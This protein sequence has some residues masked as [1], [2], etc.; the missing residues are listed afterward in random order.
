[1][2]SI[3]E[4]Q[5]V[6]I[7]SQES[8]LQ[9]SDKLV[10][11]TVELMRTAKTEEDLRIGFEKALDPLLK[12][13][14]V[15]SK[16]KYERLG[17]ETK[18][19]YRGR[20]DAVHGQVI[21]EYEPPDA[22][23]SERAVLHA[24]EQL[25]GYMTAEA[26]GHKAEPFGL[27]SRLVGVGFDGRSIFFVQYSRKKN[28]KTTTIDKE[29][30]T[31]RGPYPFN[32]ESAR[33]F[34]TYLRAL[35]RLPLT[36]EHL[37]DKFGPKSKIAP[38]AIS[39]FAD[40]L[41]N[42]RSERVLV[43][44]NEWKRLFGIVYG[45]QF[46]HQQS[47]E[48]QTLSRLYGVGK[49]TDFQELL[50][51]VHTYL[52]LLMKLIAVEL[53][54][55]KE[56]TFTTSFSYQLTHTSKDELMAQLTDIEDGGVYAKR[57]ITNFLEGD[58]FRWYLDASSPRFEEAIREIARGLSEFEP[59]TTTIDPE[60]TRD[61]LKKLYQYLVPQEV[62]H[63]LGEY[64]TPDWLAEL[65][66]NEVGY[67]GDTLKRLLDPACGS[68]TFMVL[69][70]QR[71]KD[72]GRIH[73]EP[74]LETAKRIVANIW[75]FDLNPLAVIAART[76]YLFALGHLV[77]ELPQLE[78]PIYLADSV[79]W[80]EKSRQMLLRPQ[81]ESVEIHTSLQPFFIPRIW[82]RDKGFLLRIAA[83]LIE[84]MAKSQ[85]TLSEAM[86]RFK[87]EGLVFPP[88]EQIVE[89]FYKEIIKLEKDGKNGIWARFLKNVSA[90]MVA[91]KFDFVIGNPPWIRWGYLS[92]EYRNATLPMWKEYGLF[93][94][95]GH[96]ARLGGGEKDFSMLFTY[97]AADY[98]LK[99]NARL[100]FLITQEI[101]KSK[102]AGEGF[103][104]FQLGDSDLLQVIKAH[105]LVSV[106]P[107]EGA[108]N[109]TAAIILKKGQKTEYP[110]PYTVWTR[111]KGIG[112]Q[113]FSFPKRKSLI[114]KKKRGKQCKIATDLTLEEALPLLQK[115]RLLAQPIGSPTGSWQT[116]AESQKGLALI[117]GGNVY[118]ARR[119]ASTEPYGVFW[120]EVKQVLTN[121]DL[122][123]RNL[124]GK[125]KREVQQVEERIEADLVF[126]AVRGSDI[127]RWSATPRIFVLMSQDA[128]KREPYPESQM[129]REWPRT[130]GYLTRFKDILLSRGSKTV[131]Q[132]AERTA[133]YAMFGI[134]LY[135]IAHYK[136]IW[137]RMASDI[138]AAV[139]SQHKTPF[140]YKTVI[141]TDTTSLFATDNEDEAHYLC[142]VINSTP[143]RE[144]IKSYSSAGRGFGAP[145]VMNHVG[146]PKFDSQNELHQKLAQLS[147]TL[148]DLKAKNKLD[149]V[150]RL[151]EEVDDFVSKLFEKC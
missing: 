101:F 8:L 97:A 86:E 143:V 83:P 6:N 96:A 106:Q 147:K 84:E 55:L 135:T 10:G 4:R 126:P 58:F 108:A 13:I 81:G 91:E 138:V 52:A 102:G 139:I 49:E 127:D 92:Q 22:F 38:M 56:S 44:F 100:G 14:G 54:T 21:I 17:V 26:Q 62:R 61:L 148:H 87:K 68:G 79:L 7:G 63:K 115:K 132:L 118:Q 122:I 94:L 60:S 18:T 65:V 107:F 95:R 76:N 53:I 69:A 23:S 98:Y 30:F 136:V 151:E 36:S 32:P 93:S 28:G 5:K 145:S 78:I 142:A 12:S 85:Y 51:S 105:D 124:P 74:P 11:F 120:L 109:K 39:A 70:I 29:L 82:V 45:E 64:Y 31:R 112:N 66:L 71:A 46:S 128:K 111:K 1:M 43:F 137:K 50:F 80:P 72:Y 99:K 37:A 149:E 129:K 123:V 141:P 73:N 19:V 9:V 130:Y 33:T 59:A 3:S 75:G 119:G 89:D 103:R 134:G 116:L 2:E 146:I 104:R 114:K 35:A 15:E 20:P 131:R 57:G 125:G 48:A 41:E 88:H 110:V 144:F 47:E 16:P 34:L 67:D 42:W 140:G 25:V 121:G 77:N 27:L 113:T 24:S 40:A 117:Q 90:P 150:A 133:F